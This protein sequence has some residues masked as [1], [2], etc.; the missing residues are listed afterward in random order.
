MTTT[1]TPQEKYRIY[2]VV[3]RH[4]SPIQKGI[5]FNHA[6]VGLVF[7]YGID[8]VGTHEYIS[9]DLFKSEHYSS[10]LLQCNSTNELDYIIAKVAE[11]D[12]PM[13]VFYEPDLDNLI[14]AIAFQV[15]MEDKKYWE[16]D[17]VRLRN[18]EEGYDEEIPEI[19]TVLNN[20]KLAF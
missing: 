10:V 9:P 14:T 15:P 6:V 1:L 18:S 19:W 7:T 4:L 13:S 12:F 8:V 20:L 17:N 2:G 3:L 11:A 16:L 5:Q